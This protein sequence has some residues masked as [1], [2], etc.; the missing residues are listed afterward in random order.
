M[1]RYGS[2][3]LQTTIPGRDA[4]LKLTLQPLPPPMP[5]TGLAPCVSSPS[6]VFW[7]SDASGQFD[8]IAEA[9]YLLPRP[10]SSAP[11]DSVAAALGVARVMGNLCDEEIVWQ[12]DWA[13]VTP[14]TNSGPVIAQLGDTLAISAA[15]TTTPG[16]LTVRA[17]AAG[18]TFGPISLTLAWLPCTPAI[19]GLC[20]IQNN[21]AT[22]QCTSP[23]TISPTFPVALRLKG[24][25]CPGDTITWQLNTSGLSGPIT[26]WRTTENPTLVLC[27]GGSP[28]NPSVSG[29]LVVTATV[30][31]G[32][33]TL[34]P[35]SFTV[36]FLGS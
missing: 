34:G 31:H 15:K 23:A 20:L 27:S 13:P 30:T 32:T 18:Q 21:G 9:A 12:T 17:S 11:L 7:Y 14:A 1:R 19:Q 25:L 29:S 3:T 22:E 4:G 33:Q 36:N 26:T 16:V 6:G 2:E 35:V 28:E 24:T 8:A 10:N 5:D